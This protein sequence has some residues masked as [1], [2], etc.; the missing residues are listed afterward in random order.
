[1]KKKFDLENREFL[2]ESPQKY[3]KLDSLM[4]STEEPGIKKYFSNLNLEGSRIK[5][6]E[7]SGCMSTCKGSYRS[8]NLTSMFCDYCPSPSKSL[9]NLSHWRRCE[10]YSQFRISRDLSQDVDLV[11]YYRDIIHLRKKD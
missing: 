10:G 6:K 1:M 3:K 9:C 5:F 4:L 2:L 7:R 8:Q 11:A